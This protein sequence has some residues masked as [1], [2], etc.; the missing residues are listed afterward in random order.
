MLLM[1]VSVLWPAP[2]AAHD[3]EE[4]EEDPTELTTPDGAVGIGDGIFLTGA[5][6][7][8]PGEAPRSL[9]AYH[10][11]VFVQ[12]W[13]AS[14]FFG[15]DHAGDPPP[16]LPVHR[17]DMTGTWTGTEGTVTVYYAVDGPTPYIAYGEGLVP[18]QQPFTPPPPSNWFKPPARVIEAFN[19]EADLIRTT[20]TQRASGELD[21][22]A[23]SDG[24]DSDKWIWAAG[25][26][27]VAVIGGGFW[28]RRRRA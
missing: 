10:A 7:T 1:I 24:S 23:A 8:S 15:T 21:E 18:R 16:E 25:A 27:L 13:L 5:T 22:Q 17:V 6:I 26:G 11:A 28:L 14:A 12:S 9:D 3:E 4:H 2:A 19:G 20:G